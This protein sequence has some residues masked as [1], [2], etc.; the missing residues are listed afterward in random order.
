MLTRTGGFHKTP[1]SWPLD[2]NR[3]ITARRRDQVSVHLLAFDFRRR[4]SFV[5]AAGMYP[6]LTWPLRMSEHAS[7]HPGLG[8]VFPNWQE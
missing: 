8:R 1:G 3:A 7:R 5:T 2:F 6:A 4:K